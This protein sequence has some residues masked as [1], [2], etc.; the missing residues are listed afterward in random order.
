MCITLW[1]VEEEIANTGPRDMLMF[2]CDVGEHDATCDLCTCPEKSSLFKIRLAKV[3]EPQEP[4]D[5][6]GYL[7]ENA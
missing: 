6:I 4:E 7:F 1:C 3:G 5:C 2:L